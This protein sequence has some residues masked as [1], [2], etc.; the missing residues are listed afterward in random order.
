MLVLTRK[1]EES[2]VVV[3]PRGEVIEIYLSKIDKDCA[4]IGIEAPI[5]FKIFRKEIYETIQ[6]NLEGEKSVETTNNKNL[7]VS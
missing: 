3:S 2:I 7:I 5:S 4:K 6:K 1:P